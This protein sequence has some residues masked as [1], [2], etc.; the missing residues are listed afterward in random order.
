MI[1]FN[2]FKGLY[3]TGDEQ[4]FPIGSMTSANNV[5]V[6]NYADVI[7]RPG[8]NKIFN[9]TAISASYGTLDNSAMYVVDDGTLYRIDGNLTP[10]ANGFSDVPYQWCEESSL[11]IFVVGDGVCLSINDYNNIHNL[12]IPVPV[13]ITAQLGAGALPVGELVIAAQFVSADGI[14]G[15]LS[16]SYRI[17]VP[18]NSSVMVSV[19]N[20]N[21]FTVNILA[22]LP[23]DLGWVSIGQTPSFLVINSFDIAGA[24]IDGVY[25]N[26]MSAPLNNV[27]AA[28]FF[29]NRLVV[30]VETE[31]GSVI[32]FSKPGFYHLFSTLQDFFELPDTVTDLANINGQLLITGRSGIYAFTPDG[33]IQKIVDYGTPRGKPILR[34]PEGGSL[35]WTDRGVCTFPNFSNLTKE[36]V[37]V[38]PGSACATSMFEWRGSTYMLSSN[39]GIVQQF[40][41]N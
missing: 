10:L 40:N 36:H 15:A 19:P 17:S 9:G 14:A 3:N 22:A 30:A 37:S 23:N 4:S 11:K 2:E 41:S 18:A 20:H 12:N 5:M 7:A 21:G 31:S 35:I 16:D 6:N 27:R 34:L 39:D 32:F 25:M 33:Q 13:G 1:L 38:P 24:P 26:T 29:N 8:I 28:E